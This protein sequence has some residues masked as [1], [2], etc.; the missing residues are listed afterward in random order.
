MKYNDRG[1]LAAISLCVLLASLGTS[2]V[3]I[4]LPSLTITFSASFQSV[5][6]VVIAY[7]LTITAFV[8]IAGKLADQYGYQNTL[9]AGIIAFTFSS[10]VAAFVSSIGLL[11]VMRALQGTGAAVLSAVSMAMVK[12]NITKEKTGT[13]MGL[14]GT[15][16]AL[17]TA[18]GPSAGGLLLS[19]F[20][21]PSIFVVLTI[22]GIAAFF[23]AIR[24]IKK[25]KPICKPEQRIHFADILLL[26]LSVGS[27][28]LAMTINKER[29]S[30][31]TLLLLLVSLLLGML[32]FSVQ[33]QRTH[34]L[35]DAG[36]SKNKLLMG[37]LRRNLVVSCLMMTTLIV[38]PFFLASGLGFS[39][40]VVGGIMSIG[41]VISILTGVPS[42]KIVDKIGDKLTMKIS[43]V[44]LLTGALCLAMLP[45]IFGW[46]G[47]A[48][49]IVLLTP[50]Y[51]LFQSAN[52]TSVMSAAGEK[53]LGAVSGVLN[54]SRNIGLITGAS[55]MSA[56]FMM[57]AK[58]SPEAV[59]QSG[60]MLFG[61]KITFLFASF[62]LMLLLLKTLVHE[63]RLN[64]KSE[65]K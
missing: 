56:L 24:F 36:I 34:P 58:H 6:W 22:L 41:P 32:F 60:K 8:A 48:G 39:S 2:I 63:H 54:L 28:A 3:N 45:G 19:R 16:S 29:F 12:R 23:L 49:G 38:G 51:Q 52:N 62:L 20:R 64:I 31:Q 44:L 15:M 53:Q 25:E 59:T 42:G 57:A 27:Y 7:L 65:Q 10:L 5:Q 14:L 9:L 17:G 26:S 47:Y 55:L 43:L 13:A 46:I 40:S 35:I 37:S 50:G 33:K 1:L 21:W 30:I 18:L 4:A 11:I 61:L